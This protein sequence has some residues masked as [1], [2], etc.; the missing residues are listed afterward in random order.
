MAVL[1]I[2][3]SGKWEE[4]RHTVIGVSIDNKRIFST[5]I[6][7]PNKNT[8]IK[9]IAGLYKDKRQ[10]KSSL[11]IRMFT[12]TL[13][14]TI[15]SIYR[16][17]DTIVIDE[18][19]V[20]KECSIRDLL[21]YLFKKNAN[22]NV[23]PKTIK[24]TCVGKVALS[25]KVAHSTFTYLRDPDKTIEPSEYFKILDKTEEIRK[26]ALLKRKQKKLQ[27]SRF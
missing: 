6:S 15:N 23:D 10:S 20:G 27:N 17:G 4:G 3:Q 24:F 18:E 19:Y 21:V 12:Y 16:E 14:L 25:H 9:I 5:L 2:D 7:A 11:I 13:F 8:A 1:E 22:I 26:K